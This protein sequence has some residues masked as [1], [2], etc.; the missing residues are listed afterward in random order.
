M[1]ADPTPIEASF[2][3]RLGNFA[4]DMALSAPGHGVTA[5]FGPSGCGKTTFLRCVAGLTR[6]P[7]RLSVGGEVWQDGRTFRA[8]HRRPLG[9]VFQEASLFAHLSVRGNLD[10]GRRRVARGGVR[11]AIAFDDVVE[12]LGIAHLLERAVTHLSGGERQRVAI[13]RALLGQP[14]LL[15][16]DE[17]LAALDRDSRQDILPYLERLHDALSIPVLYVSHDLAEVERLADHLVL[18][19]AGRVRA[20]GPLGQL[21]ADPALP[22]A[23]LPDAAAVL[24]AEVVGHEPEYGLVRLRHAAGDLLVPGGRWPVGRRQRLKVLAADVSLGR[25]PPVDTSIL[26]TLPGRVVGHRESPGHQVTVFLDLPGG[27]D[28]LLARVSLK[29]WQ[30]LGLAEGETVY[31]RIKAAALDR[32]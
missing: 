20:A 23:G 13:A 27:A 25:R 7:G 5:L 8:T 10:Y 19:E 9:Y 15:L 18:V 29:S 1:T 12:W 26:N 2:T 4:L 14:R 3:G 22:L 21:L 17:P 16:M 28:R 31:A 30:A 11:E 32:A 24:E 6:L